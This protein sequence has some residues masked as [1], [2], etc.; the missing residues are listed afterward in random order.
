MITTLNKY[1]DHRTDYQTELGGHTISEYVTG[2]DRRM[3]IFESN[4]DTA[5]IFNATSVYPFFSNITNI[6]DKQIPVKVGLRHFDSGRGL[7]YY[8]NSESG[9]IWEDPNFWG[10]SVIYLAAHGYKTSLFPTIGAIDRDEIIE[11]LTGFGQFPNII[12]LSGCGLF[13]GKEGQDFGDQLLKASQSIAIFGYE[14]PNVGFLHSLVI[15]LLFLTRF[16]GIKE[17][18]PFRR[19]LDI[20]CSVLNDCK[21]AKDLGLTMFLK[22]D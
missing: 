21:L 4:W 6:I 2:F 8:F 5:D 9:K 7:S 17:E 12:F 20:Y 16:F 10:T 18:D 11:A 13:E 22:E 1:E 3:I 14:S 15:E 19:V